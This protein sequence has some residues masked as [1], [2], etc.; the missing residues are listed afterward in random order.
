MPEANHRFDSCRLKPSRHFDIAT[1]RLLVID[2]RFRF[3]AGPRDAEAIVCDANL[4]QSRKIL[5]E[6][7]PTV[8]RVSPGGALRRSTRMSQ[9]E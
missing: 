3:H 1:D 5:F 8:E 9:S 6:S 2:A 4:F 7:S